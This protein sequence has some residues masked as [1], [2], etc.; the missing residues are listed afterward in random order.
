M[1]SSG[2]HR[3]RLQDLMFFQSRLAARGCIALLALVVAVPR[4]SSAQSATDT[5]PIATAW[6]DSVAVW[7]SAGIGPASG[8]DQAS[9]LLGGVARATASVGPW[10]ITYRASDVGPFLTSGSGV[11]ETA[12]LAGMRTAGHRLFVSGAAGYSRAKPY[13][14]GSMDSGGQRAFS[15]GE[16]ALAYEVTLHANAYVPGIALS[17]TGDIGR[18]KSTYSAITLSFE[19]GWF[20]L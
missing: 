1:L 7:A 9:G 11:E 10:L 12:V 8:A 15:P 18:S 13:R 17:L 5:K 4:A 2:A 3:S 14:Q 20:G 19:L 16:S 6:G